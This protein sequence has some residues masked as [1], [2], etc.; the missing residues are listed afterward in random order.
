MNIT[1]LTLYHNH[2]LHLLED[3]S[4]SQDFHDKHYILDGINGSGKSSILNELSPLPANMNDYR[5]DGYKKIILT[6][7]NHTY[8][9]TSQGKRPGKHSFL[10]D[11]NELNQG[12]T[13]TVQLEL[14]KQYFNYTPQIHEILQGRLTFTTMSAKERREWFA[15]I[16]GMDSDFIMKFYD[17]I[18]AGQRDNT[19]A[20]K[21]IHNKIAEANLKLLDD[22]ELEEIESHL[23]ELKR[24]F[25]NLTKEME[26]Y[27]LESNQ[28]HDN[29]INIQEMNN[30]INKAYFSYIRD[31]GTFKGEELESAINAQ[32]FLLDQTLKQR[33]EIEETLFSL[34]EE[35]QKCDFKS[36]HNLDELHQEVDKLKKVIDEFSQ[37]QTPSLVK[38]LVN[39]PYFQRL[40]PTLKGIYNK[41]HNE[42]RFIDDALL[43]LTPLNAPYRREKERLH[44]LILSHKKTES[45]IQL[46][47]T[48]MDNINEQLKHLESHPDHEC[49]NCHH[50][51][52]EGKVL[53]EVARLKGRLTRFAEV[54]KTYQDNA[55]AQQQEVESLDTQLCAYEKVLLQTTEDKYG[56]M[57]YLEATLTEEGNIAQLMRAIALNPKAYV[58]KYQQVLSLIPDIIYYHGVEEQYQGTLKLIEKG[59]MAST[60]EYSRMIGRIDQ[61]T[62]V[63]DEL[64]RKYQQV[65]ETLNQLRRAYKAYQDYQQFYTKLDNWFTY[66]LSGIN[67]QFTE[68]FYRS[69]REMLSLLEEDIEQFQSRIQH[70][71]GIQ[72]VIKSHEE[73]KQSIE[74]S[75]SQH[76]R[77]L[78]ILD[79]KTGLIAKSVMGFIRHFVREMNN[80][81]SQ[82]WTYP[83]IIDIENRDDFTN[84]YLFPVVIGEDA[85]ERED[86][87]QTSLGQTEVIN[88]AYRFT[89][90][91]YLKLDNYPLF[92]DEI[93]TH[94]SVKHRNNLY[95][96]IKRMVDHHYFSQVFMITHLQDVKVIMEPAN[97]LYLNK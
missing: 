7:N 21:N 34:E 47:T 66:Q 32:A 85:I 78:K 18:R 49:P 33:Q 13:L 26:K 39:L 43:S 59:E 52:Q 96:L 84:K 72:F 6:H 30:R 63:H 24:D 69:G 97:T 42:L 5:E 56:L 41:Y 29:A 54:L 23:S 92:L 20:L 95:N 35:K 58:G 80:L 77:L 10:E 60:P 2:R 73:N 48:Q 44:Q 57:Q 53:E 64:N 90:I 17:K 37:T 81:I 65:E 3:E 71:A 50:R 38:R 68:E 4:F 62:T 45:D 28:I 19:G 25:N 27:P 74:D 91:K 8:T 83:L 76:T 12:G 14:V 9:L 75:I 86:V 40:E 89:L 46:T 31:C 11:D 22:K 67:Q 1:H 82:V 94:L 51:F 87:E 70:H 36:T 15:D 79:P 88:L 61:L 55:T 93:G 16:S